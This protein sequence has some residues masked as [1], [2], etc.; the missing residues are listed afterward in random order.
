VNDDLRDLGIV[1][2]AWVDSIDQGGAGKPVADLVLRDAD[3]EDPA[4]ALQLRELV[5]S[6]LRYVLRNDA[7]ARTGGDAVTRDEYGAKPDAGEELRHAAARLDQL[8]SISELSSGGVERGWPADAAMA[9]HEASRVSDLLAELVPYLTWPVLDN[10]DRGAVVALPAAEAKTV[11]DQSVLSADHRGTADAVARLLAE[12]AAQLE[13]LA[14]RV[15]QLRYTANALPGASQH[16]GPTLDT[17]VVLEWR[18]PCLVNESRFH[19]RVFRPPGELP[20]VVMGEMGDNRSQS[21]TTVVEVV[22]AVVADELLGG[23][24]YDAVRW[25]QF[26]PPGQFHGP[27]SESGVIRSVQFGEPHPRRR[28]LTSDELEQLAGGAVRTWHSSDYTV[29]TMRERGVPVLHPGR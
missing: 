16:D 14:N 19:I 9:L 21:I 24:P 23:T 4:L 22:A 12:A 20:V 5:G 11:P 7:A 10:L 8:T 2:R 6:E 27:R 28:K 17:E 1:A 29:A 25:V 26:E 13:G 18:M 3:H 15:A